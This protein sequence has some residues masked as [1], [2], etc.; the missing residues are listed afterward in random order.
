MTHRR[1]TVLVFVTLIAVVVAA[2]SSSG[3]GNSH[4]GDEGTYGADVCDAILGLKDN[5]SDFSVLLN[6]DSRDAA[7]AA[8]HRVQDRTII[9]AE[10]LEAAAAGWPAGSDAVKRL[11]ATQRDL[12]PILADLDAVTVTGDLSKWTAATHDYTAWYNSTQSV[13]QAIAPTL[14]S[15]GV[16][17]R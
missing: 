7:A 3:Q 6:G 11:A 9:A 2:C 15:L 5:Q 8:L 14:T 4:P 1:E 10:R 13:V 16:T 17:C 12:L